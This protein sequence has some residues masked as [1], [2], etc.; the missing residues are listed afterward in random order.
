MRV[1]LKD[2]ANE[3]NLSVNTV[4][5]GLRNMDDISLPT[6][7]L[8]Q[9]TAQQLG[10][11]RNLAASSLRTNRSY[12]IGVMITDYSN[13]VMSEIIDGAESVG[14]AHGYTMMIGANNETAAMEEEIVSRMLE[15]GVDG[16]ILVPTL[17][18][19]ALLRRIEQTQTPYVLAARR[20]PEYSC[21][22]VYCDDVFGAKLVADAFYE[23]GHQQ[24]LYVAAS[25]DS[26]VSQDRFQG[27]SG[28]LEELGISPQQIRCLET[29][30][31]RKGAYQQ[32]LQWIDGNPSEEALPVT[33]IFAFSDY[34]ACGVYAAL[35]ERGYGIPKDV[36]VIGYDSNEFSTIIDPALT[37]VDNHFFEIGQRSAQRILDML[38]LPQGERM[39]SPQGI[40]TMPELVW[41][42][43]VSDLSARK[44]PPSGLHG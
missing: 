27:F 6:R 43:S 32:M 11:Q 2:I 35:K 22:Y 25:R 7:T 3:L 1:T 26:R 12:I 18:N 39:Q 16:L 41:R 19:V 4:S 13:P 21:N 36:S 40:I 8:I 44:E 24:F 31:T 34:V 14:R 23:K 15:Q 28:R 33:A 5:R 30:A 38:Q 20:Y 9:E 37:T 42:N 10:Y 17:L 29:D